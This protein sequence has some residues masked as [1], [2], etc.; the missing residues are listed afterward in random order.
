MHTKRRR[1]KKDEY[2]PKIQQ[3]LPDTTRKGRYKKSAFT[4]DDPPWPHQLKRAMV[5]MET[6]IE[7]NKRV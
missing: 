7:K 3:L 6:A 1:E 2:L 4:P 5:E